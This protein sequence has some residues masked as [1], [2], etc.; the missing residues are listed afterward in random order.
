MLKGKI[1]PFDR[2][3]LWSAIIEVAYSKLKCGYEKINGFSGPLVN[4]F[5]DEYS[6]VKWTI[7]DP[8]NNKAAIKKACKRAGKRAAF[9]ATRSAG[10]K[11]LTFWHG[12]AVLGMSGAKVE[13][14]DSLQ[15]KAKEIEFKD[16][17]TEVQAVIALS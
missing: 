5:L 7:L 11:I 16:L 15:G 10:T 12:Y 1:T 17:L 9:I 2:I 14:W 6:A 13:L 3:A 8:A 4:P